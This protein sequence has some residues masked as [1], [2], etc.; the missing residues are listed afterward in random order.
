MLLIVL[1]LAGCGGGNDDAGHE[2]AD[3]YMID[4]AQMRARLLDA[5]SSSGQVFYLDEGTEMHMN[6]SEK[7]A[8]HYAIRN[9]HREKRCFYLQPICKTT[10]AEGGCDTATFSRDSMV[11]W[12]WFDVPSSMMLQGNSSGVFKGYVTSEGAPSAYVGELV[13]WSG[14][15]DGKECPQPPSF[16]ESRGLTEERRADIRLIIH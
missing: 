9:E 12:E 16:S 4:D 3:E 6:N 7:K 14:E 10:L 5:R 11:Y 13:V 2:I 1:F 15:R 8:L